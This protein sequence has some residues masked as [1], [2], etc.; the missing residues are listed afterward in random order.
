MKL[1]FSSEKNATVMKICGE[2]DHRYAIQ[3]RNEADK[4]IVTYPDKKF[5]ID[6]SEV[7]FMDSSGIGVIIGRY[8]LIKSFGGEIAI[9]G[10]NSAV[11][12]ILEMSG[13]KKIIPLFDTVEDAVNN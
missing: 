4:K 10:V 11:G 5:V 13:I 8:K 9:S 1:T 12:K 6:L 2:I 7:S 3:I